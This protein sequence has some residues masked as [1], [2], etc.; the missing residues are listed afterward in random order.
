[1]R[2]LALCLLLATAAIAADQ[3]PHLGVQIDEG[4]KSAAFAEGI[5]VSSVREN[6]TAAALGIL[7][8]DLVLSVN[9]Q[10]TKSLDDL[11][12]QINATKVGATVVIE[13]QRGGKRETLTGEMKAAPGA[14]ASPLAE[15]PRLK[16]KIE[17]I[18][19][20]AK[21]P[22][23][24]RQLD[25][26]VRQLKQI[27]EDLPKAAEAFKKQYPNGEFTV[28]IHLDISSDITAKNPVRLGGSATSASS[29]S[30]AKSAR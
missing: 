6:T 7:A 14:P 19:K 5:P 4:L 11:K 22:N 8:G 25:D 12:T 2:R 21:E 23:L 18:E 20:A 16:E 3:R 30:A 29:A 15:L 9:G 26:L 17:Q 13:V 28:A 10:A 24:M 27:E 1:M